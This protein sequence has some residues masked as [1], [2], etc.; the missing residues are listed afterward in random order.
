MG[1]SLFGAEAREPAGGADQQ[2]DAG[3]VHQRKGSL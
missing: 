1:L 3:D 2:G